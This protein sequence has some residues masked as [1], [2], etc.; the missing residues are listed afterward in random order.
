LIVEDSGHRVSAYVDDC[1]QTTS[2]APEHSLVS[3]P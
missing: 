1:D 2:G 3:T